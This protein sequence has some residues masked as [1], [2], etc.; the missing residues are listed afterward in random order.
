[1]ENLRSRP[2]PKDI[3]LSPLLKKGSPAD[4]RTRKAK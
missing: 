4:L 1:M 2:D 3:W